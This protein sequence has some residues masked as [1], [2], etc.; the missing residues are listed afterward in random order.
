MTQ[1]QMAA[2][3]PQMGTTRFSIGWMYRA[4]ICARSDD[5]S[6]TLVGLLQQLDGLGLQ[7]DHLFRLELVL[8]EALN[9]IVEHA[10]A[11]TGIGVIDLDISVHDHAVWCVLI[12]GGCAMP[13]GKVPQPKRYVL[14]EMAMKDLPEGGFGWG[15]IHDLTAGLNYQRHDGRNHLSF[16]ID[17]ES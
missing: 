9:N 5:V 1:M 13:N 16:R 14:E 7:F 8:A 17:L 6:Q 10:Y 12:D 11:D 4:N 3:A 15:L 2:D